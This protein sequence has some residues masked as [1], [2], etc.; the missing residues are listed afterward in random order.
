MIPVSTTAT[1]AL[2]S[3][4]ATPATGAGRRTCRRHDPPAQHDPP[5]SLK[6]L[7]VARGPGVCW[8]VSQRQEP[9]SA[10]GCGVSPHGAAGLFPKL[11]RENERC[12]LSLGA[13]S[14]EF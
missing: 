14:S 5:T 8:C 3:R 4:L 11:R 9:G 10:P 12:E 6:V 7:T 2:F 1:A 13:A